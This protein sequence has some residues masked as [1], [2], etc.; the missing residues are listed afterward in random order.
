MTRKRGWVI[1]KRVIRKRGEGSSERVG[2]MMVVGEV[3]VSNTAMISVCDA[4]RSSG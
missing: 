2:N 3:C 4:H 1:R